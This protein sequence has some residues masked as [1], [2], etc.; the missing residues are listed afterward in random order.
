MQTKFKI[1]AITQIECFLA[2]NSDFKPK[3]GEKYAIEVGLDISYK[4]QNENIVVFLKFFSEKE[5]QPF[6]FRVVIQGIFNFLEIP[7]DDELESI[8]HINC[9]SIMFPFARESVA[10]LT[11]KAGIQPLIVDPINFVAL[12]KKLK[13]KNDK[14][15]KPEK[16]EQ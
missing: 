7:P 9:A 3:N 14:K 10:D 1:K 16:Q 5:N 11:R 2:L 12:Y 15:E 6:T 4:K 8:I 13:N